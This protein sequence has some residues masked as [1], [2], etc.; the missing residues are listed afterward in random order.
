MDTQNTPIHIKLWH[1]GLLETLFCQPAADDE[2]L[3]AHH[4][5]TLFYDH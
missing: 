1:R 5:H 2:C 4:Q 3:Y